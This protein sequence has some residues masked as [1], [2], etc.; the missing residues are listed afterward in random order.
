M[1]HD[2]INPLYMVS[3]FNIQILKNW[4]DNQDA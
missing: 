4:K 1:I 3:A 2:K